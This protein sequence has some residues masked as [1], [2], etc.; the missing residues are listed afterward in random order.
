MAAM[1]SS[2]MS[3]TT[4][5]TLPPLSIPQREAINVL[6]GGSSSDGNGSSGRRD[7]DNLIILAC[8]GAGKTTTIL[9]LANAMPEKKFLMMVFNRSAADGTVIRARELGLENLIVYNY[10]MLGY[11]H[12]SPECSNDYGLNRIIVDDLPV[13]AKKPLPEFD[14]LVLDEQQDMTPLLYRFVCKILRDAAL[15]TGIQADPQ[16]VLLGD[17][18]QA[19]YGFN[20]AHSGFLTLAD[21]PEV[22]GDLAG[23]REWI[24]IPQ[25]VCYRMTPELIEFINTQLLKAAPGEEML[26]APGAAKGKNPKPRYIVCDVDSD[27]TFKEVERLFNRG[28]RCDDIMVLAPSLKG[29]S[30]AR[31]LVNS[32]ALADIPVEVSAKNAR[33]GVSQETKQGKVWVTTYHQ[34]KG[35]ESLAVIVLGFDRSYPGRHD[36]EKPASKVARNEQYVACSRALK[37]LITVQSHTQPCLPFID[38]NTLEKTCDIETYAKAS[39]TAPAKLASFRRSHTVTSLLSNIPSRVLLECLD[40]LEIREIQRPGH[41]IR[42]EPTIKS[43][44]GLLEGVSEL[45]GLA[46]P[47]IYQWRTVQR[48]SA[49]KAVFR[50]LNKNMKRWDQIR[51]LLR[52]RPEY[53]QKL[54]EIEQRMLDKTMTE[55]DILYLTAFDNARDDGYIHKLLAIPLDGYTWL[56]PEH[57]ANLQ[58]KLA[59]TIPWWDKSITYEREI[60]HKIKGVGDDSVFF[61]RGKIDACRLKGNNYGGKTIWEIKARPFRSEDYIEVAVYGV[62]MELRYSSDPPACILVYS[63]TGQAVEVKQ[64]QKGAYKKILRLLHSAKLHSEDP[65]MDRAEFLLAAVDNFQELA[66]PRIIKGSAK[67]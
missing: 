21:E 31:Q 56:R 6:M 16:F 38:M 15:A 12:Y 33:K 10:H 4:T 62:L 27:H 30:P 36:D 63:R 24:R 40:L 57:A 46:I 55:A 19:L 29:R 44:H 49:A 5:R 45:T 65:P 52:P 43:I 34:S 18:R 53:L 14:V 37:H 54:R 2:K 67:K 9:Q 26:P 13:F 42:I 48:C 32:L 25:R 35:L 23:K 8:A 20:G 51:K 64:K 39:V 3:D 7:G 58:K 28:L 41:L 66:G 59:Q 22:F 11:H 1:S 47:A 60:H 17:P 61:V 50:G